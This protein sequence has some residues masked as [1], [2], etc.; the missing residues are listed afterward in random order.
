MMSLS[1]E[2]QIGSAADRHWPILVP[3]ITFIPTLKYQNKILSTNKDAWCSGCISDFSLQFG[4][5]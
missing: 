1:Q 4:E 5:A 3:H 2:R